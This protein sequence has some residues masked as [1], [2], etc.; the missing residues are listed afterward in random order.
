MYHVKELYYT[1]QG[2]GAQSGRAAVFC[3]FAG[4]N[5]WSGLERDR[6]TAKCSFCDTNFVGTDGEGGGVFESAGQL[7]DAVSA[8]WKRHLPAQNTARPYVVFTGGEPLLQLDEEL[9]AMVRQRGLETAVETNG[10][11]TVPPGVDWITVS[12]K[13]RAQLVQ[14]H[15]NELKLVYPQEVTPEMVENLAFKYFFLMPRYSNDDREREHFTQQTVDYCKR[16]PHWRL[17]LQMQKIVGIP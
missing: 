12:P 9:V 8:T 13:P 7:A 15:G 3:R 2:E 17:T 5:L 16:H 4:C 14:R 10:T 6:A 11:Q 1:L